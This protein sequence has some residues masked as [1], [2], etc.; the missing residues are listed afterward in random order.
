MNPKVEEKESLFEEYE[1]NDDLELVLN[2]SG[3][4]GFGDLYIN[5]EL[6]LGKTDI[7][8]YADRYDLSVMPEF[9]WHTTL[10][11][12]LDHVGVLEDGTI[13]ALRDGDIPV[14]K[15]TGCDLVDY[16]TF[17]ARKLWNHTVDSYNFAVNHELTSLGMEDSRAN[18][19]YE[20]I[21]G[22]PFV[23][24]EAENYRENALEN[25]EQVTSDVD[26]ELLEEN[27]ISTYN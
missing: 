26:R 7:E 11:Q 12:Q 18:K 2:H 24:R 27:T 3:G 17:S 22:D 13:A 16:D 10:P 23:P 4:Y 15:I 14:E 6:S 20:Q 1:R 9:D 8:H 5:D 25:I 19:A 21:F